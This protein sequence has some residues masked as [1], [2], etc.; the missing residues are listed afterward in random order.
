MQGDFKGR[1]TG[2][3]HGKRLVS[4]EALVGEAVPAKVPPNT[5][6]KNTYA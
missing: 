2:G 6:K 3:A 4:S 5:Q 1:S